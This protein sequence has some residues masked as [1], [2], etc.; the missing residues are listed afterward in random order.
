MKK[1]YIIDGNEACAKGAYLFSELCGIYPITPASPMAT[2]VD[3]WSGEG[4]LN[5]FNDTVK[6]TQMQS[7]AGASA[8]MHGSLQAGSLTT[9]FTASQGLLLMI[10][11]M[12]KM[13]G[14]MLPG[15]IHVA[16]RSLATHALSI[17]GDHQDVYACR[18][19]GFCMLASTSVEDAYYMAIVS[20]L[21]AI[22]GS[23]PF[24]HF[25]D[26]FR[27]SHELNKVSL[28]DDK[29]VLKLVN[30]DKI[31][32]FK[33]RALNI[34]KEITRGTSQTGD[35]YFQNTEVRNKYYDMIPGIVANN[36]KKLN[37][38]AGTNYKPFNYYGDS[39]ATHVIVAMGSVCDTIKTVVDKLNS[40]GKHVGLIE[41]H[42]YRP[43]SS[44]Y[45]LNVLPNTVKSVSV[46]DRTKEAGSNG[47][48]LYLDVISVL[49]DKDIKVVGGRYGLSSKDV[50]LKDINAV[51]ENMFKSNPKNNFTIGIID[52]VTNLSL[53]AREIKI[54]NNYKEIKVFGFGSDGM[55]GAS[56]NFMKVLGD[57]EGNYVQGYFEYDS[58]KSGGV[59]ISH[60]RVGPNKINAPYFLTNP[61]F[62]VVSKDIYLNRYYCLKD[63]KE[64]G[65]LLIS[66]NKSDEELN[67]LLT[68][69][70]KKAIL[71]KNIKV[72]V[73]NL[74]ELN[75]KYNLRG[76]INNIICMYMLK[77]TGYDK[78]E[79]DK[80]KDLV[81]KTYEK[82]GQNV[83]DNN[84]NAISE[85]LKYLEEIDNS[86]F[87]F[88]NESVKD[89]DFTNE[90]LMLRGNEL[91]VSDFI[92]SK[93]GTF[94]GGT[95]ASDKRKVSDLVPKWCSENCIECNQCAF[96]CPHACIRPFSLYD[97]EL[98]N[99]HLDKD[100]V[101]KSIGE[102]NKNFYV[103]VNESN[104][105]GCGLCIKSCPGKNGEKALVEGEYSERHDRISEY[106]FNNHENNTPFNKYTVKGIG[107][108]KPY[109]EFSGAC[110]GCGEAAYIKLIT[111]LYGKNMVIANATG[112]SS[113]YGGSL[114]LTP[115]KIPWMNSLFEDN[116]E[117]GFGI[118][119]SYKKMR[120]RLKKL[121]Y[122]YKDE[123]SAEVKAT[124]K[125]WIDN[126]ED[127][128]YTLAIKD[129]LESS[130]IP[131][132][133][134]KLIDYIPSRKVWIL[135][136]DGWA[137]DIG[138]GGLD[139]VLHSN[140]NINIMVLDTEVYSNTGGQ[141]SKS[142]RI[143]SVAEFASCGK[144][145]GKKDLFKIAMAI[146][147][148][149][150]ASIS[151]G[152]NMMQTLKVLKEA[153]EHD[154]PS[155]IIAYS[156]C[157]TQGIIGGMNNQIDEQKM[158]VDL[159]YN[160]LMRYNP[161][162]DKLT[163]DSKEPDFT[164]YDT[165]F[166]HELRYKNLEVKNEEEYQR[167][168]EENMNQS[169]ERYYYYKDLENKQNK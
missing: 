71:D 64:N 54:E 164:N 76:K 51:F 14:E 45:L 95:A 167:L 130:E 58:K 75:K 107:F 67:K 66:S 78:T 36:M 17:F 110:A 129:K 88:V 62:I 144:L 49:K 142:T 163:I 141:K 5:I 22:E 123:V 150:V 77:I 27:T 57:M 117:F 87:T 69:E 35:V 60:L 18:S 82:K 115:Y 65:I 24:L 159:G 83:V 146:P 126:M 23:L 29:E 111:E 2:L 156:T 89:K 31:Y 15:V 3:K 46:L 42:L 93:D 132:E 72:Y 151:M 103:S 52:D 118:H 100:E 84:L 134:R 97:N 125:E 138:Y 139:H 53:E 44:K 114:P 96:V 90:V 9:T 37:D 12:Y 140:E 108:K 59:T 127:D 25:F 128:D 124:F 28:L 26:G 102:E 48:P 81:K 112:C 157:I 113:I 147:N 50:P 13:A 154:G 91:K 145:E 120:E 119:M 40:E 79:I 34:G 92:D 109:F 7:E 149:Y 68:N 131:D 10:P 116:A 166:N 158:L 70:N 38:L 155:L 39:N 94:K 6:V 32:E 85:G 99:A 21:S 143:G 80:F 135:G 104:C 165:I 56:K 8:L 168:Y 137:Y 106:L 4:K 86:I 101:I 160:L 41:V 16:A 73:A 136:G 1:S 162:E 133:I 33:D 47:E 61:D 98:I 63:I 30:F 11:T 122:K 105:T 161:S 152:A 148:V 43:F 55:V 74:D 169:K 153:Y 19:T 121:M 20:H